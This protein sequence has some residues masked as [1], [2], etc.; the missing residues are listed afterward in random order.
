[1]ADTT[2]CQ[3]A[4]M[5][6]FVGPFSWVGASEAPSLCESDAGK[7]SGVYLW[8]VRRPQGGR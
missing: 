2:G 5:L 4:V 8:A 1:M 3:R 7:E 6:N